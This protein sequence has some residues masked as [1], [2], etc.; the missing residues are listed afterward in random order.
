MTTNNPESASDL[1]DA[2]IDVVLQ[3]S[4]IIKF[5][6]TTV[7][8]D[9]VDET[10]KKEPLVL[11]LLPTTSV[12][13]LKRLLKDRLQ[14]PEQ[15]QHLVLSNDRPLL[16]GSICSHQG[17]Q[18]LSG[19][20]S[21]PSPETHI[22]VHRVEMEPRLESL[23]S[24]VGL[25]D[26]EE[27]DEIMSRMV[28]AR[29]AQNCNNGHKLIQLDPDKYKPTSRDESYLCKKCHIDFHGDM[30]RRDGNTYGR[31]TPFVCEQCNFCLCNFCISKDE[32]STAADDPFQ[33]LQILA[34]DIA[35]KMANM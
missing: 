34:L 3:N 35:R 22:H 21:R 30:Y 18:L 9:D 17:Q 11:M 15:E 6:I 26:W 20:V 1:L 19:V 24:M 5:V 16:H 2:S 10:G 12:S 8:D 33:A 27:R 29:S 4:M 28:K 31:V 23:F 13:D 14:I 7:V 32:G 25:S